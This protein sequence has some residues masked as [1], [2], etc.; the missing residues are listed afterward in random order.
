MAFLDNYEDVAARIRR[1]HTT[2]PNNRI[3]TSIADFNAEKG[4]VLIE[5]RIFR[6]YDDEKPAGIDFAFGRV[7]SYNVGMKRWFVEDTV[8]SAIGR[9]AG[10][11]L[12]AE[13]RPTLQNMQ[14]VE[15]MPKAFIEKDE[16][17]FWASSISEDGFTSA[18]Q[19]I[20]TIKTQLGGEMVGENPICQHGHRI[21][22][23]GTGKTGKP[24]HGFVCTEKIKANQ[25]APIWY[26][27]TASG[28][29]RA[30]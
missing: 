29:W 21:L 14:Q 20:D 18:A 6:N 5:C 8:T 16:T 24:Y 3:E 9:C 17:D 7:E 28:K 30:Q 19:A 2:Y 26:T 15:T 11:V 4:F 13:K 25:C 1:L 23:E 27:L 12:G 22:K 10:L